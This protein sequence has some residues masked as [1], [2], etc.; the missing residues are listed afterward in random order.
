MKQR[1]NSKHGVRSGA[2]VIFRDDYNEEGEIIGG[3]R[4][5]ET[6]RGKAMY[7]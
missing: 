3:Y 6:V 5:A 4:V 1:C 7:L 2:R